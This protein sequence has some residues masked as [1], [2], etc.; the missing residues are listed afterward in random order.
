MDAHGFV[1]R[2]Y[3]I[4]GLGVVSDFELPGAIPGAADAAIDVRIRLGCVPATL[5]SPDHAGPIWQIAADRLL[6]EL[7]GIARFLLAG[8][9]EIV[10][11]PWSEAQAADVPAFLTGGIIGMLLLQ[12]G[13]VVLHASA[14]EMDGRAALIC[15]RSGVGKSTLAAALAA[16]GHPV[17]ADE[18]CVL[19]V[20]GDGPPLAHSDGRSL[21]LWDD[22]VRALGL[23]A[24]R[25]ERV[26]PCLEK[27]HVD[28]EAA[29]SPLPV[30]AVYVLRDAR[31][32]HPPG[33]QRPNPVDAALLLRRSAYRPLLVRHF[34]QLATYFR[35][36]AG[37]TR[38][39][40]VFHLT[41]RLDISCLDDAAD[42]LEAHWAALRTLA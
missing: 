27:H 42:A 34:G 15:G 7:P 1:Q 14:V 30:G 4:G 39:A 8:G 26:R 31:A 6:L 21:K 33:V 36:A 5:P 17:L 18:L 16:R 29:A 38:H 28:V 2:R 32:P 9:A 20:E 19:D 3:R 11:D 22:A 40:G 35:A 41:R 12:R 13:R 10:V 23:E 25:G 24:R 37:V